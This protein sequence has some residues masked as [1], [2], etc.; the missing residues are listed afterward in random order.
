MAAQPTA[1]VDLLGEFR[2]VEILPRSTSVSVVAAA[3]L[4]AVLLLS[5]SS[6]EVA[7]NNSTA[8]SLD[9]RVLEPLIDANGVAFDDGNGGAFHIF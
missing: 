2:T 4:M 5:V 6:A 1:T 9:G 8:G 3:K 7:P